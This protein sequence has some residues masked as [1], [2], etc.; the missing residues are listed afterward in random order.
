MTG[1]PALYSPLDQPGI[2][3]RHIRV[4]GA[5]SRNLTALLAEAQ[6]VLVASVIPTEFVT[7]TV[8]VFV[9]KAFKPDLAR[10][11]FSLSEI[12]FSTGNFPGMSS[13][14]LRLARWDRRE[15]PA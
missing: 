15:R 13:R 2:F 1:L 8:T 14:N 4:C 12:Y 6:V 11:L 5:L 3:L 9:K 10:P 7:L